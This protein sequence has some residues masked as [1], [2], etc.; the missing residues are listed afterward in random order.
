MTGGDTAIPSRRLWAREP[1][2]IAS[3]ALWVRAYVR[4]KR[5]EDYVDLHVQLC[6]LVCPAYVC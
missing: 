6:G 5:R 4:R 3:T 2:V 1:Q